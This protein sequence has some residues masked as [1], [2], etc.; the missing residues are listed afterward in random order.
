MKLTSVIGV[1]N[2]FEMAA[3][4]IRFLI[5]NSDRPGEMQLV[6]ID[7]GSDG[8]FLTYANEDIGVRKLADALAEFTVVRNEINTGNYP[9]FKQALEHAKGEIVAFLHSDVFVL[10]KGWDTQVLA[11]FDRPELGLVGFL[12]STEIDNFGGRGMG[13]VSN[14]HAIKIDN[15]PTGSEAEVHGRR[16]TG[17]II[18]GSVV[19]GCV[20]IFRKDVLAGLE[21]KDMPPHHF[22]D[23]LM[24]MQ[25]IEAGFRVGILGIAFSHLNGQTANVQEKWHNYAKEWCEKNLGIT[26]PQEWVERNREWWTNTMNPSRGHTPNGYDHVIYLEAEKRFLAEYRD[27]KHIVP[28]LYGKIR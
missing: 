4:A 21:V 16:D 24:S 2:N 22:Y 19:D 9:L 25:V 15:F 14:M 20:M 1:L 28:M 27:T 8:D 26:T 3:Q 6:I 7:N 12:G 17:F 10:Q 13:T 23:R 5:E 11:Q 18:D